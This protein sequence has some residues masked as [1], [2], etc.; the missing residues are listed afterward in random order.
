MDSCI[1]FT[2]TYSSEVIHFL[3]MEIS[4]QDDILHSD[5]FIKSTDRNT[6]LDYTSCHSRKMVRSL[7][8][9]QM[10]C[11]RRVVDRDEKIDRALMNMVAKFRERGYPR[12]L[13]EH[14]S[15]RVK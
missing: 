10:L 12:T 3:D 11:V 7:P 14:H 1:T 15:T 13:V 9:S 8:L 2:V 6:L 5:L 4:L